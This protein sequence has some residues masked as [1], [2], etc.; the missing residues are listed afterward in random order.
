MDDDEYASV[1]WLAELVANRNGASGFV[2]FSKSICTR[3]T[4]MGD[5]LRHMRAMSALTIC[6]SPAP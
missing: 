4:R 6:S 2:Q 3:L 5:A 1:N